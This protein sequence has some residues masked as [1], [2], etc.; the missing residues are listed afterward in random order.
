LPAPAWKPG[1]ATRR[2]SEELH[3]CD[4]FGFGFTRFD[5]IAGWTIGMAM[6]IRAGFTGFDRSLVPTW[7]PDQVTGPKSKELVVCKRFSFGFTW[8]YRRPHPGGC[9][10]N[11]SKEIV[12]PPNPSFLWSNFMHCPG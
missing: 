4:K 11:V 6:A 3:V 9:W 2:E 12:P 10:V 8:F 7:T 5:P 1:Q